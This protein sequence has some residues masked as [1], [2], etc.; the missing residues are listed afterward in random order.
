MN[1]LYCG[2]SNIESGLIL[3]VLSLTKRVREPMHV[4]VI[5]M[6]LETPEKQYHA[7]SDG[8][9]EEI[10]RLVRKVSPDS[11]A[12]KL[13][14]TDRFLKELPQTNLKTKFTPYCMLRLYADEAEEIPDRILYLDSDVLCRKSFDEFYYQ[15]ISDCEFVGVLDYYGSW[16]FRNHPLK[17]DYVNS[18]VLL[19]NMKK[20]RETGLF[21]QCRERCRSQK[22]F[23]PDQSALN[24]LATAKRLEARRYNEQRKLREDTVFQHFTTGFRFFPVFHVLTVKPWQF[25]SVHEKLKLH[26]YDG[27]FAEYEQLQY[28]KENQ[29]SV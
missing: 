9:M 1:I 17:R 27:L 28:T 22:M 12:R 11:T 10:R 2:D 13:D 15:D 3:S 5:T 25:D 8:C 4:Y 14:V 18:G 6:S 23:M 21:C 29:R 26:E 16:F 7:V 24:K 20:I 19:L